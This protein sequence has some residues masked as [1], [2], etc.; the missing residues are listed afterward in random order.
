ML[1]NG[2]R[3]Y[4]VTVGRMKTKLLLILLLFK[5]SSIDSFDSEDG[6]N[7][8][9]FMTVEL[10]NPL[11]TELLLVFRGLWND[12]TSVSMHREIMVSIKTIF[13]I[14]TLFL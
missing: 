12:G 9:L 3:P 7:S 10:L 1:W 14:S 8:P 6:E 5:S 11:K 4:G 2:K 13:Q